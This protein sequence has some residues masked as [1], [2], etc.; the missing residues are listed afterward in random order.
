LQDS[1]KDVSQDATQDSAKDV[2]QDATQDSSKDAVQE[3]QSL[4]MVKSFQ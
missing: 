4:G 2:P 1:S 3:E